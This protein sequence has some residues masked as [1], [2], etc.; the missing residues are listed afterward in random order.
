[1]KRYFLII[2]LLLPLSLLAQREIT[3]HYQEVDHKDIHFGF[4][5][6][7]NTMDFAFQPSMQPFG[8][9]SAVLVPELNKLSPGVHVGIV[10][11]LR[12][13]DYL[14]FRFLPGISLGQRNILYYRGQVLVKEMKIESTFIDI[15]ILLKYKAERINNYRPYVVGGFNVRND[16]A[17]NKDFNEDEGIYIK[18]KPF[19]IYYELGFGIDFYLKY[20]KLS[21]ELKYSV[22]TMDVI[23]HDASDEFPEYADAVEFMKSR[24]FMISFHFE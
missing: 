7:F 22:G 20:F 1:M 4:T 16:M 12:L 21:T 13:T 8:R 9:D 24:M 11:S 3:L 18:M 14:D 5:L 17:R 23:S 2:I 15:P 10:S 6:G 19:D